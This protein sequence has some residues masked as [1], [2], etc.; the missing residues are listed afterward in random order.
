MPSSSSTKTRLPDRSIVPT[1]TSLKVPGGITPSVARLARSPIDW[2]LHVSFACARSGLGL[3]GNAMRAEN[4]RFF[5]ARPSSQPFH[6]RA[7]QTSILPFIV[8][9]QTS[10]FPK[11]EPSFVIGVADA[12]ETSLIVWS[13]SLKIYPTIQYPILRSSVHLHTLFCGRNAPPFLL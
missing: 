1:S 4:T 9:S 6:R 10:V 13:D 5:I 2:F 7:G 11:W 3:F 12:S 8:C